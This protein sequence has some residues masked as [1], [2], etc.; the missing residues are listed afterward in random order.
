M[1][2]RQVWGRSG[3]AKEMI[4]ERRG[5]E[6]S[7]GVVGNPGMQMWGP[8]GV[9]WVHCPWVGKRTCVVVW[10][11]AGNGGG[12]ACCAWALLGGLWG[13]G[14]GRGVNPGGGGRGWGNCVC[15]SKPCVAH[16]PV[17]VGGVRQAW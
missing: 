13:C 6:R 3:G 10:V 11:I 9:V 17:G 12:V 7:C 14:G 2:T 5:G 1:S 15:L 8:N 16:K 4:E